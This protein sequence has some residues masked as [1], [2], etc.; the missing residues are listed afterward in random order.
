MDDTHI[1]GYTYE[2]C[3]FVK[4]YKFTM[5]FEN[6]SVLSFDSK[7]PNSI[8]DN[9]YMTEKILEPF[10]VGSIP[11]YWGEPLVYKDFN[12]KSF[13]NWHDCLN[14]EIMIEKII[15]LDQDDKKY[16][17][18]VNEPATFNNTYLDQDYLIEIMKKI[19]Q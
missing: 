3:L 15:K 8:L 2:K 7:D 13:V 11:L 16:L 10:T 4:R 19:T 17:E 6:Y 12:I 14:D 18:M 9:G 1:P 5:S